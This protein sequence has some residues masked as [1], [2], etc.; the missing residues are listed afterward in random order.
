MIRI[1]IIANQSVQSELIKNIETLMPDMFYTILPLANG[2][3]KNSYK[4]GDST[5]PETNFVLISYADDSA[6]KKISQIV[7]FVKLKFS[8]E[9]IKLFIL[10]DR[11]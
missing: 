5:W 2:K 1:E 11:E 3:G 8:T 10:H 7:R 9:G 4:L 6:E